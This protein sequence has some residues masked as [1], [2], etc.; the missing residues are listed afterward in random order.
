MYYQNKSIVNTN[1]LGVI[2]MDEL[3]PQRYNSVSKTIVTEAEETGV[4]SVTTA[5][6]QKVLIG[7]NSSE[8]I[9]I[10][11]NKKLQ[12]SDS[13]DKTYKKNQAPLL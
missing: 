1:N 6:L 2:I 13:T 7:R 3:I 10:D 4:N 5:V 9:Q 12:E 11:P 8:K